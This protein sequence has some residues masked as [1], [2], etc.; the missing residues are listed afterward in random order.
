[1]SHSL[2]AADTA[3]AVVKNP[4]SRIEAATT[5]PTAADLDLDAEEKAAGLA[6]NEGMPEAES[7]QRKP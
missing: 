5:V 4:L 1:M 2:V 6:T 3:P 7:A